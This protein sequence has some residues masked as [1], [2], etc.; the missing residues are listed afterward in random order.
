MVISRDVVVDET[1]SWSWEEKENTV[2]HIPCVLEDKI[3]H[4]VVVSDNRKTQRMKFPSTRLARHE[5]YGD[6][7]IIGIG[8]LVHQALVADIEP[9]T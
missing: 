3:E 2:I 6:G 9:I 7:V 4:S 8:D 5:V 1:A